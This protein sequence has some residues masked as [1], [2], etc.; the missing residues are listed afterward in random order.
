VDENIV[1]SFGLSKHKNKKHAVKSEKNRLEEENLELTRI[2]KNATK[3]VKTVL[4]EQYDTVN[5]YKY[6][7]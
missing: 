1:S 5:K 3:R 6:M 4:K 2:V 7:E